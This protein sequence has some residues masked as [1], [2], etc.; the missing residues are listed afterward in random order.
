MLEER[1]NIFTTDARLEAFTVVKIQ[2]EVFW[3]VTQCSVAVQF[4]CFG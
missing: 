3:V 2:I 1:Q 4:Q